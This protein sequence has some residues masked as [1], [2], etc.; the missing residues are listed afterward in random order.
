MT[1]QT[2]YNSETSG[3]TT[4]DFNSFVPPGQLTAG[5][6][7]SAGLVSGPV[8]FV[9]PLS[10]GTWLGGN[11]FLGAI[12]PAFY[13]S[14]DAYPNSPTVLSGPPGAVLDTPKSLARSM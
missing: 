3:L 4:I 13:P 1:D 12:T 14:Y 8:D 9:G 2:T 6:S 11:Y 10:S 7:T 5:Y